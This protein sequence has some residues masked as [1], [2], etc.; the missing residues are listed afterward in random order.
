MQRCEVVNERVTEER[1]DGYL[2]TYAY[3]GRTYTMQTATPPG[4][5]VRLAVDVRP[6]DYGTI[7]A[8]GIERGPKIWAQG[9]SPKEVWM[10]S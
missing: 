3:Q 6:V 8:C 7:E 1:I 2:V 5:R 4:D 9:S 10:G